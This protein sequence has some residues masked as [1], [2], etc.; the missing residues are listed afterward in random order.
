[1]TGISRGVLIV[2]RCDMCRSII[3]G[4]RAR[5]RRADSR[6]LPLTVI[7]YETVAVLFNFPL[8]ALNYSFT[9]LRK[10]TN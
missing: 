5:R 1:M 9:S 6:T 2:L 8:I 4:S 10:T 3:T 7:Q